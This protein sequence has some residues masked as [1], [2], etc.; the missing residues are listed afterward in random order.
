MWFWDHPIV[1]PLKILVVLF[2]E[3]GHA[4]AALATGG[5][6]VDIGLSPQ[7]GGVT[8]TRGGWG[9]VI[10]NA[11]YLGSLAAG[12]GLLF[13]SRRP[14]SAAFG[15]WLVVCVLLISTALWVRPV[16]SFAFGF[17]LIAL[18]GAASLAR[19]GS[20]DLRASALRGLGVFSVLYALWD[21][22]AD[23]FGAPEGAISDATMLAEMTFIPAPVWGALWLMIGI[24]VL[25]SLRRWLVP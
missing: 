20:S 6:V 14:R 19:F 21:I 4:L 8:H 23:V 24:S 15:A 12:V 5:E 9:L 3:L 1:W 17:A 2:H 25:I 18:L 16:T 13:L 22:R 10:L 11:G 7:Q